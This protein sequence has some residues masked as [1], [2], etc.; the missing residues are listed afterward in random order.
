M[1]TQKQKIKKL[2]SNGTKAIILP[3]AETENI[4]NIG[5]DIN[6]ELIG[7]EYILID[8]SSI[9]TKFETVED[10]FEGL[11]TALEAEKILIA[12]LEDIA[13]VSQ[14]NIIVNE[15]VVRDMIKTALLNFI[16]KI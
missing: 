5:D 6:L 4:W 12:Q 2:N 14:S 1:K 11:E 7:Q 3:K 15:E 13:K 16:K 8:K 9:S 10:V